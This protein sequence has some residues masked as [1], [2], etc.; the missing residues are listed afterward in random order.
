MTARPKPAASLVATRHGSTGNEILM[1]RRRPKARFAPDVWVFPGGKLDPADSK[2]TPA[3]DLTDA[4]I[5]R[6]SLPAAQA[7]ALAIAAI[8]ET[9][10]ETGLLLGAPGNPGNIVGQVWDSFRHKGW[11]PDLS[12]LA[13]IARAITPTSSPIRF[14]ARFF[15]VDGTRLFG[16]LKGSGELLDLEWMPVGK[17][18]S[19]PLMDV[20]QAVIGHIDVNAPPLLITYRANRL[21]RR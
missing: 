15:H 9:A 8:R 18:K 4:A 10:E 5:R 20:T 21:I 16:E 17:A 19:L 1:G 2:V 6:L 13:C 12:A 3:T 7:R 11:A 14:H